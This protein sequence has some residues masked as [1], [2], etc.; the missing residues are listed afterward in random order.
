M[1]L[2]IVLCLLGMMV[3][4]AEGQ[5]YFNQHG[6]RWY[7]NWGEGQGKRYRR[8]HRTN[9]SNERAR[10]D[11]RARCVRSLR[12]NLSACEYNVA[13]GTWNCNAFY[14]PERTRSRRNGYYVTCRSITFEQRKAREKAARKRAEDERRRREAEERRRREEAARKKRE[15]EAR[16]RAEAE[17]RRREEAERKRR[18]EEERRRREE[19]ARRRAEEERRRREEEARREKERAEQEA[20]ER[21]E[22]ERR[23]EAARQERL[24]QEALKN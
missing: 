12:N 2:S 18:E 9:F 5:G 15:E 21:A 1:N 11:C 20:R 23:E 19:E 17:R 13:W 16:R 10:A 4:Q 3:P 8:V 6:V 22:R 24:R 7:W 14:D